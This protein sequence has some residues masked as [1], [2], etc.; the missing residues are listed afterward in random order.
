MEDTS[1]LENLLEK[2][3]LKNAKVFDPIK[4]S[5]SESENY[6]FNCDC[7]SCQCDGGCDCVCQQCVCDFG[8]CYSAMNQYE[9]K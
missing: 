5:F 2:I 7:Y 3:D 1:K 6:D 9:K 4:E 8:P